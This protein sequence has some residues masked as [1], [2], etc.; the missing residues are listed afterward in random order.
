M[1]GGTYGGIA[2]R[3]STDT[4]YG[5]HG[6]ANPQYEARTSALEAVRRREGL[7]LLLKP[8]GSRLWRLKYRIE[9]R[10]KLLSLG[11]YPDVSLKVARDRRDE[12]RKLIA[13][14]VETNRVARHS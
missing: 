14:G 8:N 10:E 6:L 7:F 4:P 13:R 11:I 1:A 2:A 12:A 9:G 3:W 5:S